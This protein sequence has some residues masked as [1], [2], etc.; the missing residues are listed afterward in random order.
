M[1]EGAA[2]PHVGV[3]PSGGSL[4]AQNRLKP[5]LQRADRVLEDQFRDKE[6]A[7]KHAKK[8][9]AED[10]WQER[11]RLMLAKERAE[12]KKR[13][14]GREAARQGEGSSNQ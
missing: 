5:G 2:S 12:R 10:A 3:P 4:A 8:D 13:R 1:P 7:R 9:A 11:E 6:A 14:L